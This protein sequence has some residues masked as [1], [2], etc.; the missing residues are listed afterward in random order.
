MNVVKVHTVCLLP[1]VTGVKI[2]FIFTNN[3]IVNEK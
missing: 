2:K 1:C 3:E